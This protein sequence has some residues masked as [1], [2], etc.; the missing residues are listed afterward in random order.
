MKSVM[1]VALVMCLVF[2]QTVYSHNHTSG[3]KTN[4][5][6]TNPWLVAFHTTDKICR[7]IYERVCA[8]F[9]EDELGNKIGVAVSILLKRFYKRIE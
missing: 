4:T 2:V 9:E 1:V 8:Y 6:A 7:K 5:P 3:E